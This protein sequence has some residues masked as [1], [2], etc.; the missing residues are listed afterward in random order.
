MR[1][2]IYQYLLGS[3]HVETMLMLGTNSK[4]KSNYQI[5]YQHFLEWNYY[6]D[7]IGRELCDLKDKQQNGFQQIIKCL[8]QKRFVNISVIRIVVMVGVLMTS[9]GL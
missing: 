3:D 6:L 1:H 8:L 9:I 7:R 2:A 5:L 4:V